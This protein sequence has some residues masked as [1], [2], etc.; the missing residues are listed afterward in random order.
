MA[1]QWARKIAR[2]LVVVIA[3]ILRSGKIWKKDINS[4]KKKHEY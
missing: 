1:K 2:Y 3:M 4:K